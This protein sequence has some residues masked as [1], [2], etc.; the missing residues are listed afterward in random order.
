[1]LLEYLQKIWKNLDELILG[2][3][4]FYK[5]EFTCRNCGIVKIYLV[6]KGTTIKEFC[7]KRRCKYCGT[8]SLADD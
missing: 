5:V 3:H 1:M 8:F 4:E 2:K 7:R 6:S